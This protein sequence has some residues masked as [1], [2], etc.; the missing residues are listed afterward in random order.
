MIACAL[1]YDLRDMDLLS[2]KVPKGCVSGRHQLHEL[3]VH[4]FWWM[5]REMGE[6]LKQAKCMA[7]GTLLIRGKYAATDDRSGE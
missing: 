3:R 5:G 7:L 2:Q 4:A 1:G 6:R